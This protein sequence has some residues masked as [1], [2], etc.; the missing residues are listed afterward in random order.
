MCCV[1]CVLRVCRSPH[2]ANACASS[3]SPLPFIHCV[4]L[5]SYLFPS[6]HISVDQK[7]PA[8]MALDYTEHTSDEQSQPPPP[9]P[10]L[11]AEH[12]EQPAEELSSAA[13]EC[14]VLRGLSAL[15]S[16][17]YQAPHSDADPGTLVLQSGQPD[18]GDGDSSAAAEATV[19]RLDQRTV[20]AQAASAQELFDARRQLAEKVSAELSATG[21]AAAAPARLA[22]LRA[23][24]GA[25]HRTGVAASL[26]HAFHAQQAHHAGVVAE[27]RRELRGAQAAHERAVAAEVQRGV[28]HELCRVAEQRGVTQLAMGEG[29]ACVYI[30]RETARH[31]SGEA[32]P[33]ESLK[34][35][36]GNQRTVRLDFS[37]QTL[38]QMHEG[39]LRSAYEAYT[40]QR[41]KVESLADAQHACTARDPAHRD[42]AAAELAKEARVLLKTA[43]NLNAA[44]ENCAVLTFALE[45]V[46]MVQSGAAVDYHSSG[47]RELQGVRHELRRTRDLIR[48]KYDAGSVA[49]ADGAAAAAAA[50]PRELLMTPEKAAMRCRDVEGLV[51]LCIAQNRQWEVERARERSKH[52]SDARE[53]EVMI[54]G[55]EAQLARCR[56]QLKEATEA[57]STLGTRAGRQQPAARKQN[58]GLVTLPDADLGAVVSGSEPPHPLQRPSSAPAGCRGTRAADRLLP[59]ALPSGEGYAHPPIMRVVGGERLA[60]VSRRSQEELV[61]R[62]YEAPL[63]KMQTQAQ[64][65]R[66]KEDDDRKKG[67]AKLPPELMQD[68]NQRLYYQARE[69]DKMEAR[70]ARHA[71]E[72][73]RAK[74]APQLT[75]SAQKELVNKLYSKGVA[76]TKSKKQKLFEKLVLAQEQETRKFPS[77]GKQNEVVSRLFGGKKE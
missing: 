7:R 14:R 13:H 50:S 63:R 42:A 45:V 22:Q 27:L 55:Y 64:V 21:A 32:P 66:S 58:Q 57:A 26:V 39:D 68:M 40:R 8:L 76:S 69:A 71:E 17:V 67:Q 10:P 37:K 31:A 59:Y 77:Q 15:R 46:S 35:L 61:Q 38:A 47:T 72:V 33:P 2:E 23:A 60:K 65:A 53:R 51:D 1:T 70:K 44:N 4:P 49:A 75:K 18:W 28:A 34:E 43:Q 56:A 74:E 12:P 24:Q 54:A 73:R 29:G 6:P 3:P 30:D 41:A 19:L 25:C 48:K 9:T 20:D 16:V 36:Q 62:L 5:F 11:C 52:Y